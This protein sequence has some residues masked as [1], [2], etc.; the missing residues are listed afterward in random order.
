MMSPTEGD[1]LKWESGGA[2]EQRD[3]WEEK[4]RK[5]MFFLNRDLLGKK[6]RWRD[7]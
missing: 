3:F 6:E 7:N 1:D 5:T 4:E 2:S